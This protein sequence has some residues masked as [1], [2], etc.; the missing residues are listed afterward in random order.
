VRN[1]ILFIII[2]IFALCGSFLL[3]LLIGSM[4]ISPSEIFGAQVGSPAFVVLFEIRLPRAVAAVL[5]GGGLG[6]SGAAVQGLFRN[7]LAEPGIIGASAGGAL[8]AV[9]ALHF[10]LQSIHIL[11][12]PAMAFIG[13]LAATFLVYAVAVRKG[14]TSI[15]TLLLA[16]VAITSLAGACTAFI[17]TASP[18]YALRQ[19]LFWLMGGLDARSWALVGVV[20]P[21]IILGS[22]GLI[23]F[24]RSFDLMTQGEMVASSLGVSVSRTRIVAILLVALVTGAAV[25]IS[26]IIGFV[27]LIVPHMIRFCIGPRHGV[28]LITSFLG[29]ATLLL[30]ADVLSRSMGTIELRLGIITAF[31][32]VPFF[33][34]LLRASEGKENFA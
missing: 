22:F 14:S 15:V 1:R 2:L 34:Y 24:S 5:V 25:A 7:P 10:A 32:G 17:L 31:L 28:L 13:A 19:Q 8:G 33:I 27:G 20:A 11:V 9:I 29:G 23:A 12:L 30:L 21:F 4:K 3:S 6:L 18:A 16:G 26:G